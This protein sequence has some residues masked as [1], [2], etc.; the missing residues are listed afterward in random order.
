MRAQDVMSRP[1]HIV[2]TDDT[3]E[4][5]TALLA[6]H[7]VTA[8]PVLDSTGGL[9]GMVSEGDL[10]QR[11]LPKDLAPHARD[12]RYRPAVVADVM[13][14]D[15]VAMR[16]VADLT[17][18]A[19]AM[20]DYNVRSVPIVE[21]GELVGIVSRRD[22]LRAFIRPDDR[23]ELEVQHRLDEY[24]GGERRWIATVTGGTA[25]LEGRFA[26][27]AERATVAALAVSTPGVSAVG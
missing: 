26:D 13:T 25:T 2:R 11:W 17:E 21:D 10:L 7:G 12:G 22:I 4:H 27:L 14:E 23:T 9:V 5:A 8:A 15:V 24:A 1:V 16:S 6:G 20:I 3:I 19:H 18:L